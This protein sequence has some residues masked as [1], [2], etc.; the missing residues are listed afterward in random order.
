MT[1]LIKI[2]KNCRYGNKP[3]C[4]GFDQHYLWLI[5]DWQSNRPWNQIKWILWL[6]FNKLWGMAIRP[7]IVMHMGFFWALSSAIFKY[8]NL[9][10]II[11]L[12][13]WYFAAY[14]PR[15]SDFASYEQS[16]WPKHIFIRDRPFNLQGG[17]W[18]FVSFIIF[19]SDNTRVRIFIYFVAQSAKFFFQNSTLGY[20]TNSE[21]DYFFFLHQNWNIFSATLRIRIFF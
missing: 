17:L 12:I 3:I 20:M 9:F 19:F 1:H 10:K 4:R 5:S 2:Y 7:P 13:Y 11:S 15:A 6:L 21:S 16:D 14:G 8:Y 18:F